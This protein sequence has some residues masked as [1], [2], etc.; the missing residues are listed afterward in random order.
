[1]SVTSNNGSSWVQDHTIYDE[2]FSVYGIYN[3]DNNYFDYYDVFDENGNCVNEGSPFY[4]LPTV[5]QIKEIL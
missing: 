5:E 3:D 1:M 4:Q 2:T